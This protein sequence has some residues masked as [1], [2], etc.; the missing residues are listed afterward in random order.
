MSRPRSEPI[1]ARAVTVVNGEIERFARHLRAENKSDKTIVTYREAVEQLFR[2]LAERGM[3]TTPEHIRR[4]LDGEDVRHDWSNYTL[5]TFGCWIRPAPSAAG[6]SVA[7]PALEGL[8]YARPWRTR[9][10]CRGHSACIEQTWH[11][12]HDL[13]IALLDLENETLGGARSVPLLVSWTLRSR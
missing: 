3:P 4:E 2:H 6:S 8:A 7:W 1:E 12:D 13:K 11:P 5:E 9:V 10:F